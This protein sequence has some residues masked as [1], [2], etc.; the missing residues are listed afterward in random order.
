M[1]MSDQSVY[2][3]M[4]DHKKITERKWINTVDNFVSRFKQSFINNKT[5]SLNR[6][7]L[8]MKLYLPA[9]PITA[10]FWQHACHFLA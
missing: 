9:V 10:D 2:S 7:I 1:Y 8:L 6:S 4:C 3:L 5:N